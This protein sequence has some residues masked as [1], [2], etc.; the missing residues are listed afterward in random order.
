MFIN[1]FILKEIKSRLLESASKLFLSVLFICEIKTPRNYLLRLLVFLTRI[2]NFSYLPLSTSQP[3][4]TP[5]PMSLCES[6]WFVYVSTPPPSFY[7]LGMLIPEFITILKRCCCLRILNY[8]TLNYC[9]DPTFCP[10]RSK[11]PLTKFSTP[12]KSSFLLLMKWSSSS[13]C[14]VTKPCPASFSLFSPRLVE[15]QLLEQRDFIY[16]LLSTAT[17]I[18][19]RNHKIWAIVI[20]FS[21]RLP[22]RT[23]L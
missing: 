20:R 13:Y 7:S 23:I 12:H 17:R 1:I 2:H 22:S 9:L 3:L 5:M 11:P 18:K 4:I 16:M 19:S 14:H 15:L 10:L 6:V 8:F 21:K